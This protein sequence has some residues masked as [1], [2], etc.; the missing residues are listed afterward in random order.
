MHL[1]RNFF[2]SVTNFNFKIC[3][4]NARHRPFY[5]WKWQAKTGSLRLF[6][7]KKCFHSDFGI[8]F[9]ENRRILCAFNGMGENLC[10]DRLIT[11]FFVFLTVLGTVEKRPFSWRQCTKT[12][13]WHLSSWAFLN[14][15][16][17]DLFILQSTEAYLQVF[18]HNLMLKMRVAG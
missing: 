8:N 1:V 6:W 4:Q 10:V 3:C 12:A 9:H 15:F 17:H 2:V 5:R 16:L 18:L 13:A 11:Q 7:H 14:N